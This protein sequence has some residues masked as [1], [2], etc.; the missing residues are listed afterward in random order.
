MTTLNVF[1]TNLGAYAAGELR[2]EWLALP[3]TEEKRRAAWERIGSPEE[4]FFTDYEAEDVPGIAN[5]L[6]EFESLDKLEELAEALED[7]DESERQTLAAVIE[8]GMA[9]FA[10]DAAGLLELCEEVQDGVYTLVEGVDNVEDLG[11]YYAE[12]TGAINELPDWA[13]GY[14][15]YEAYGRDI[16]I[17]ACGEFCSTGWIEKTA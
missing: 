7:M 13:R 1:I 3:T 8:S 16:S 17:E 14:F 11:Y 4:V 10:R 2:G 15:D 5:K 6:G 9:C 12:E